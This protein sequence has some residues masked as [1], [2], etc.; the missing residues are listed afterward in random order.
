MAADRIAR[1]E[2]SLK[3][4]INE[5]RQFR[6]F[7]TREFFEDTESPLLK[8][9]HRGWLCDLISK[10]ELL[11]VGIMQNIPEGERRGAMLEHLDA[12]LLNLA[13]T[14]DTWHAP[15]LKPQGPNPLDQFITS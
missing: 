3:C 6:D 8:R 15:D 1:W 12:F 4:W 14:L 9:M 2:Q 7:E 11:G 10:G 13:T 5:G